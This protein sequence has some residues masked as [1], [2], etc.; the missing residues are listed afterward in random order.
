MSN[1]ESQMSKVLGS[2]PLFVIAGPCVIESLESCLEIGRH[3]KKV[4]NDLGLSYIFKASFESL[5]TFF[6]WPLLY[7]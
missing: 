6:T 5:H 1:A 7:F 2:G 3:V 4:C